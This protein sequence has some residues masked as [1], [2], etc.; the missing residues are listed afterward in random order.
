MK[1][2]GRNVRPNLGVAR[3]NQDLS[4]DGRDGRRLGLARLPDL[5]D[6]PAMTILGK[7]QNGVVELPP[8]THL[9]EGTEVQVTHHESVRDFAGATSF[10]DTVR[11]LVGSAEGLPEDFAAEHDHFI[12]G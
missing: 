12:Y 2:P 9:P 6:V 7:V 11:D 3:E 4:A 1:Y 8:G 5:R 10:F